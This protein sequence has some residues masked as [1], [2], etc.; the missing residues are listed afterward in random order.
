MFDTVE[1]SK[2][3]SKTVGSRIIGLRKSHSENQEQFAEK[4]GISRASI[5]N[6]EAGRQQISLLLIYQIALK[7]KI[8]ISSLLPLASDFENEVQEFDSEMARKLEEHQVG[9]KTKN[10]INDLIKSK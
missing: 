3:I 1:L 10:L 2:K 9:D 7:Y 5:S 8:E 6:I 4:I